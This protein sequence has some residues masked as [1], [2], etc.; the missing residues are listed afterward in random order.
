MPF[1]IRS[2]PNVI[3]H[4]DGDAFFASVIQAVNPRLKGKP[5][6]TGQERGIATAVSY[7]AR[8]MGIKRGMRIY[9]IKKTFP[10]CIIT[11][12]DYE[13]YGL[14]SKKMFEILRS[15][16]PYVE[17]YSIDEGFADI[18]GLRKPYNMNYQ[19][20]GASIKQKIESSLGI[21]VSMGV[22]VTKSL[23]KLASSFKK[24]SGLTIVDGLSI[25]NILNNTP[26]D[27]VWGIGEQT[28]A[29]LKKLGI[30]TALTFA[31]QS[32]NFII[33]KLS[34]PFFEIWQ[35][36]RGYKIYELNI[37]GKTTYQSI[38]RSQT[39]HPPT[40]NLDILWSR[41][42]GHIE[43]AFITAR[44]YK[45][46]VVSLTIFL[47]TQEFHY[48]TEEILLQEPASYPF[49]I[50]NEIKKAFDRIYKTKI[51]YRTAGCTL[52]RLCENNMIQPT[53]FS[54]NEILKEKVKKFYPLY[55]AKKIS[56]ATRLLDKD[57]NEKK[58]KIK[59]NLPFISLSNLSD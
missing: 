16:T 59:L 44:T 7:E 48:H 37:D 8:K 32:E 21:T 30:Y 43:E 47:K 51:L 46:A 35:E 1:Q 42:S 20:I 49:L 17:E 24:P 6:V 3:L 55:E 29:Y 14:F 52:T 9:E 28:T 23:A 57:A 11:D 45:Y 22:S 34:K 4:C 38:T 13:L 56:F 26:I 39:F 50:R 12:S 58:E 2:W 25:E 36:L 5:V 41:L 18:K 53:L 33:S 54:K 15:F 27:K 31:Q 10:S 19:E 40:N